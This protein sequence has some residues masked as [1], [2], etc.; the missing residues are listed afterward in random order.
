MRKGILT[1]ALACIVALS[2]T[3]QKL[4]FVDARELGIHGYTQKSDKY[5]YYRY[6]YTPYGFEK[7]VVS[8]AK[9]STGLYVV[10][11]TNSSQ[12]SASW[13]NVPHRMGDNMTGITQHGL[14]LYIKKN[15][16]WKFASV[17]RVS[18][19]PEKNKRTKSLI[20]NMAEGEK[21]CLLYL[22]LWCELKSLKIG[23]DEGAEIKGLPSPFR[24]KV[25]V[26]GSSITHGASASRPGL[27]YPALLTRNLGIDF[28]NF[29]FSGLCKMQPQFLSFLKQCE[30]DA[31]LF[32]AFS[33][34][35]LT[36]VESRLEDFVAE[37]TK[38][39]PG[40]PLIFLQSP[41]DL[42][43]RFDTK[44]Y[45]RRASI[46][47][48]AEQIMKQL[49]KQYKDVYFLSVENVLGV[50]GTVDNSHPT[51]LGFYRFVKAYQPKI[52]K[53]LKKYGIK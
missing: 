31:F 29:G 6:D 46:N 47:N 38:A 34:S 35:T 21:E 44:K 1:L 39:H 25:V 9:K 37:L 45:D 42:D 23:I 28:V 52:A 13:E 36:Q 22:P 27:T 14:D 43:S 30:A 4:H 19:L 26:H 40:K 49:C 50:D 5:P 16:E 11:K 18:T 51:D 48:K 32:D 10:F 33:N 24:H 20:K 8:H 41:C 17:G 53:I 3:A 2:A 12:I 7:G 15:G